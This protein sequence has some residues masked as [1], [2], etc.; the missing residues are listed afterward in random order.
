MT[1]SVKLTKLSTDISIL[2]T[3]FIGFFAAFVTTAVWSPNNG[4]ILILKW[5]ILIVS[6]FFCGLTF[7]LC[8]KLYRQLDKFDKT[9]Q[10]SVTYELAKLCPNCT[11][12]FKLSYTHVE[13][14]Q[15]TTMFCQH[16]GYKINLTVP[17]KHSPEVTKKEHYFTFSVIYYGV[18]R[19]VVLPNKE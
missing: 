9:E 13:G 18:Y 14:K 5:V 2:F 10:D 11:L 3:A 17:D 8:L 1:S 19:G 7:L 6:T 15:D 4:V 12:P 16:C